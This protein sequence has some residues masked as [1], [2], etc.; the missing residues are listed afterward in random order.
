[1]WGPAAFGAPLIPALLRGTGLGALM[2]A[3]GLFLFMAGAKPNAASTATHA[4]AP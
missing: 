4:C 3:A 2:V 1:M